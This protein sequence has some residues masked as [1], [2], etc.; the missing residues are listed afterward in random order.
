MKIQNHHPNPR[1]DLDTRGSMGRSTHG[2][3]STTVEMYSVEL[4]RSGALSAKGSVL[5]T[6]CPM[7]PQGWAIIP[8]ATP[9]QKQLP[10]GHWGTG[11]YRPSLVNA[12]FTDGSEVGKQ[13]M[14]LWK[15]AYRRGMERWLQ[16]KEQLVC[17]TRRS[18]S[19]HTRSKT[20]NASKKNKSYYVCLLTHGA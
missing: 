11:D 13:N 2:R 9:P 14:V 20:K 8:N 19:S 1:L 15:A 4:L 3:E 7:T 18:S 12:W 10:P 6:D 5:Q 17:T 16:N